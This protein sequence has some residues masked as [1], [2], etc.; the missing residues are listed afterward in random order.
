MAKIREINECPPTHLLVFAQLYVY[1]L[2]QF[3]TPC[4]GNIYSHSELGL[5]PLLI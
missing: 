4:L 5:P 2:I 1:S 3:G